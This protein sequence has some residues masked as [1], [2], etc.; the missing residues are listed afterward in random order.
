MEGLSPPKTP[1]PLSQ[2]PQRDFGLPLTVLACTGCGA[3]LRANENLCPICGQVGRRKY[4]RPH[5]QSSNRRL[6]AAVSADRPLQFS[7]GTLLL[8]MTLAAACLALI[9]AVPPLGV[10]V[11][12]LAAGA[13]I[14]TLLIARKYQ[15]VRVPFLLDEKAY[16]FVVSF[17][18]MMCA[19]TVLISMLG[20]VAFSGMI[21]MNLVHAVLPDQLG[22]MF[23]RIADIVFPLTALAAALGA[24]AWF[25][26]ATFPRR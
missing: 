18:L 24:T 26:W 2:R 7:I 13:L 25:L 23:L 4:N 8:V 22:R 20:L 19:A 14:R 10:I 6:P 3:Y 1:D 15:A 21:V 12:V 17:G 9:A 5:D 11:S 16:E